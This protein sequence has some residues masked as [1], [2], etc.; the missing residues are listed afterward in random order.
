MFEEFGPE[1]PPLPPSGAL[2]Q[3]MNRGRRIRRQRR[4]SIASGVALS[5]A[6]IGGFALA[7]PFHSN[8]AISVPADP[9]PAPDYSPITSPVPQSQQKV[10]DGGKLTSITELDGV[11]TLHVNREKFSTG[12]AA[13]ADAGNDR[14]RSG[15]RG[16]GQTSTD[17]CQN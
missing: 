15:H 12:D 17:H 9:A 1:N 10:L 13:A 4:A 2:E 6:L 14:T 8:Q 11:I 3:A 16:S 7:N 5:A